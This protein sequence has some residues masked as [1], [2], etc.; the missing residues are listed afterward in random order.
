MSLLGYQGVPPPTPPKPELKSSH[1][2]IGSLARESDAYL[3]ELMSQHGRV[4]N[5]HSSCSLRS[6]YLLG[7][8]A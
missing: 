6:G 4:I 7:D 1:D 3:A 8:S 5:E 2:P